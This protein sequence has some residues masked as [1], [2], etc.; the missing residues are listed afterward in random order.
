VSR[1][2]RLAQDLLDLVR[3]EQKQLRLEF[4]SIDLARVVQEG[5]DQFAAQAWQRSVRLTFAGPGELPVQGDATRLAQVVGNL[6]DNALKFTPEGGSVDVLAEARDGWAEVQVKDSGRGFPPEKVQD[7]F[8]P[9]V[10]IHEGERGAPA[11]TGLGLPICKGLVEAHGGRIWAHS[12][13]P[14]EGATFGFALPLAPA[15]PGADPERGERSLPAGRA[16][17]G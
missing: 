9:F 7:V 15:P 4:R 12:D 6:L 11:G 1:L 17:K 5:V 10:R 3:I 2:D 14:G 16:A 13:G 8:A